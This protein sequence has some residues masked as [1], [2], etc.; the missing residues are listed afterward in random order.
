MLIISGQLWI[1]TFMNMVELVTNVKE[2][3][4]YLPKT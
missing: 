1:E 4:T 3:V 2:Q